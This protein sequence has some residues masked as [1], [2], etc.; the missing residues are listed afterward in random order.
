MLSQ[1]MFVCSSA[2]VHIYLLY[3]VFIHQ[4]SFYRNENCSWL[5]P[6][7]FIYDLSSLHA[8]CYYAFPSTVRFYNI[9]LIANNFFISRVFHELKKQK[10]KHVGYERTRKLE[11][12]LTSFIVVLYLLSF[13]HLW[14][15][16]FS[17]IL[18]ANNRLRQDFFL[19]TSTTINYR[20]K[21]AYCSCVHPHCF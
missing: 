18:E 15:I 1:L 6:L 8:F 19:C 9:M 11:I 5:S 16:V 12:P 17:G 3:C 4:G 2:C 10:N 13:N 20:V 21:A 7:M 14:E